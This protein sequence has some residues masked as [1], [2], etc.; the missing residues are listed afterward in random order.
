MTH[1]AFEPI[2]AEFDALMGAP[3][4]VGETQDKRLRSLL[5]RA[6]SVGVSAGN[7]EGATKMRHELGMR[8]KDVL[9]DLT[10]IAENSGKAE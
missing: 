7:V 2:I 8:S 6:F 5:F 1:K 3:I 10:A 4:T 9:A